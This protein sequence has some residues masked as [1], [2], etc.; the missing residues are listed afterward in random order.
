MDER[1]TDVPEDRETKKVRTYTDTEVDKIVKSRLAR[2]QKKL[3]KKS[4]ME[5]I[6]KITI[7]IE[8][9]K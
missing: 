9:E 5:N 7:S 8:F 3:E 2:L 1:G 4:E 6:A